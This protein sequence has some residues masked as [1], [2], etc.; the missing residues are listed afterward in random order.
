MLSYVFARFPLIA[1][2]KHD[3][4]IFGICVWLINRENRKEN[5]KMNNKNVY[6]HCI[7]L[8]LIL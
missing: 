1:K 6:Q 5:N 7:A 4:I 3:R 8:H 2:F